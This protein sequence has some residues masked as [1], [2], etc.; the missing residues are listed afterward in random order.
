MRRAKRIG[1]RDVCLM[2][3][4]PYEQKILRATFLWRAL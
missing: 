3:L 4:Y 2:T 1:G